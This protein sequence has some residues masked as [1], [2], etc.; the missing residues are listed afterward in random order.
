M[1]ATATRTTDEL[2]HLK[3]V[4]S[5]IGRKKIIFILNKID[6]INRDEENLEEIISRQRMYLEECGF[7]NPIICPISSRAGYLA[8]KFEKEEMSRLEKRELYKMIDDFEDNPLKEYYKTQFENIDITEYS[9][10]ERQL[11]IN[12]GLDYVEK[13][14]R[15]MV[16]IQWRGDFTE[17]YPITE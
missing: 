2:E 1:N 12:S 15:E 4:K 11:I 8:K 9:T 6:M 17:R 13:I 7:K 5:V 16:L 14:I 3:F 10:E